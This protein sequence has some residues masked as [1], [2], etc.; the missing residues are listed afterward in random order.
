MIGCRPT[1]VLTNFWSWSKD[2]YLS[3][4]LRKL[5]LRLKHHHRAPR[6]ILTPCWSRVISMIP[7]VKCSLVCPTSQKV[8]KTSCGALTKP[9]PIPPWTTFK[10]SLTRTSSSS[11]ATRYWPISVTSTNKNTKPALQ[12]SNLTTS[13]TRMTAPTLPSSN[14]SARLLKEST[15]WR[16]LSKLWLIW[17]KLSRNGV[18][19]SSVS[20]WPSN[21]SITSPSITGSEKP[22]TWWWKLICLK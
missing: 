20:E 15:S 12:L 13:T 18:C 17:L 11:C 19:P 14:V 21:R 9:S 5:T 8:F 22:E 4:H 16:T 2:P 1:N 10:E 7:S 6:K 3:S